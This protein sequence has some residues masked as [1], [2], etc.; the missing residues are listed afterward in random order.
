MC[1]TP[2][3]PY[4][5]TYSGAVENLHSLAD[6]FSHLLATNI[7]KFMYGD[8]YP[9]DFIKENLYF[10]IFEL[11]KNAFVHG[12][13]RNDFLNVNRSVLFSWSCKEN[14]FGSFRVAVRVGDHGSRDVFDE[15]ALKLPRRDYERSAINHG[16]SGNRRG[17]GEIRSLGFYID[18]PNGLYDRE[19][20]EEIGKVVVAIGDMPR[21]PRIKLQSTRCRS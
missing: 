9:A 10:V 18:P 20:R 1:V 7:L 21:E 2:D 17:L 12:N 5:L 13:Q 19:T 8:D 4:L 15:G 14:P 16:L 6:Q 3:N 11:I